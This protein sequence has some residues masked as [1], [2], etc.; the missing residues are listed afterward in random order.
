MPNDNVQAAIVVRNEYRWI[1]DPRFGRFAVLLDGKKMGHVTLDGERAFSVTPGEH[2]VRIGLWFRWYMSPPKIV[3]VGPSESV[4][5]AA[6]V[7][8][9]S[10]PI[11]RMLQMLVHPRKSLVLKDTE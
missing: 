4:V 11:R 7:D 5:L 8:R 10:S 6:D 1:A 2:T 9:D 3:A